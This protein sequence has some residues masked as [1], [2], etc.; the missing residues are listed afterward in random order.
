MSHVERNATVPYSAEQMFNLVNDI[1]SYSDFLPWCSK[2]EI[3]S[4]SDE[5]LEGKLYISK[6]GFEKSFATR[7][8]LVKNKSMTLELLEGPFK[9]FYGLW[10]FD[11]IDQDSCKVSFTMDFEFSNAFMAM[12]VGVVFSSI[13]NTMFS[14]FCDRADEVYGGLK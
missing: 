6:G 14:A 2:A 11:A 13:A 10:Q 8:Q 12:T 3:L 1:E 5:L 7:N 9:K 4:R